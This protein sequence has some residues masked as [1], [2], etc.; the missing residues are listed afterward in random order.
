MYSSL[1]ETIEIQYRP[2]ERGCQLSNGEK[3]GIF[4]GKMEIP[5]KAI[6]FSHFS[7]T[8]LGENKI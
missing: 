2:C 5:H 1:S 8:I 3:W 6:T 7:L 4:I